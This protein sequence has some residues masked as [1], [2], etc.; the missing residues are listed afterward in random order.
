VEAWVWYNSLEEVEA[1]K[2]VLLILLTIL[3]AAPLSVPARTWHVNPEGTGDAPTIKAGVDSAAAGDTLLLADGTYT[4][5]GNRDVGVGKAV[6]VASESGNPEACIIDCQGND[7]EYHRGFTMNAGRLEGLTIRN[8]WQDYGGALDLGVGVAVSNCRF[9]DNSAYESGGAIVVWSTWDY[10][11]VRDCYFEGNTAIW[12][13]GAVGTPPYYMVHVRFEDC[14]FVA[15]DCPRGAAVYIGDDV[16]EYEF[17]MEG[18]TMVGNIGTCVAAWGYL[19]TRISRTIIAYGTGAAVSGA[20]VL[21]CCDIYGNEGGD[22]TA[23]IVSG[24]GHNGNI[25][26]CPSFCLADAEPYDFR[27]CD[28]SPCLPGNHPD[29]YDCGLIGAWDEGCACGPTK[30]EPAT[31]GAIKSIY[32]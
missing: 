21:A 12:Y 10:S 16:E 11:T 6:T 9:I 2:N 30:T 29:G 17:L 1:M 32:R 3:L 18:C 23:N 19:Y 22:W 27:L 25:S 31:W 15:N 14:T 26:A 24:L 7:T 8:G 13:G 20:P 4:G 5:N 28:D